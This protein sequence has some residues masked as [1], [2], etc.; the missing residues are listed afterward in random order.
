MSFLN[1]N[2]PFVQALFTFVLVI[3]TAILAWA[4]WLLA[5]VSRKAQE[6]ANRPRVSARLKPSSDHGSFIRLVVTNLGRGPAVNISIK[7][8][9]DEEDFDRHGMT[10]FRGTSAPIAFLSHGES[11]T[12]PMG[13][14]RTLF[15]E[16]EMKPFSVVLN[17]KDLD[18]KS[19]EDRVELNVMQFKGLA[20]QGASVAWRQME[21]LE[22][23]EKDFNKIRRASGAASIVAK[24]VLAKWRFEHR[25]SGTI[26]SLPEE[27][28]DGLSE[29][30]DTQSK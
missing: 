20:W 10:P 19:Y 30:E 28:R 22:K 2:A 18:D 26:E 8:E 3:F 12:Y 25:R 7:L 15:A 16:P 13:A 4:T 27:Y 9:G 24:Y 21:A 1:E 17:Y 23:I 29:D 14:D 11:D 6:D 5:K